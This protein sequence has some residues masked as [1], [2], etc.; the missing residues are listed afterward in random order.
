MVSS[1]GHG[2]AALHR[3]HYE[4]GKFALANVMAALLVKPGIDL[5][6]KF[7]YYYL[8]YHKERKLVS[9]M[10]GTANTSLTINKLKTVPIAF[11]DVETQ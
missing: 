7:L 5:L 11:P 2:H 8:W 1:T 10:A 3:I 9:L 6:P 4:E